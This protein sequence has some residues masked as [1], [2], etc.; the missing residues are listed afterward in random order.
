MFKKTILALVVAIT[1][2]AFVAPV[3]AQASYW[4]E[5]AGESEEELYPIGSG[6]LPLEIEG[7]FTEEHV[8]NPQREIGPCTVHMTGSV[9]N[10]EENQEKVAHGEITK[11]TFDPECPVKQYGIELCTTYAQLFSSLEITTSGH[12]VTLSSPETPDGQFFIDQFYEGCPLLNPGFS[13]GFLQLEFENGPN[14]SESLENEGPALLA[15]EQSGRFA[16]SPEYPETYS[17]QLKVV[18]PEHLGLY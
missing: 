12:A 6:K 18:S 1:A 14:E 8:F 15:H 16:G 5:I 3:S 11:T 10:T 9:W 17:A 13:Y 7:T 4:L 2:V